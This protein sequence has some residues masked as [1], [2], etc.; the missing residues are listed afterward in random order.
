[1]NGKAPF[2]ASTIVDAA[3]LAEWLRLEDHE[4]MA[5]ARAELSSRFRMVPLSAREDDQEFHPASRGA[6]GWRAF[7]SH[8][9]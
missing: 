6:V 9:A 8:Q 5:F 4:V 7:P 1:M 3:E 2:D